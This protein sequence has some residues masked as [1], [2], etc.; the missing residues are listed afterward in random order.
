MKDRIR[1]PLGTNT[2][3]GAVSSRAVGTA[4]GA[5]GQEQR[6]RGPADALNP[7]RGTGGSL[8]EPS[9]LSEPRLITDRASGQGRPDPSKRLVPPP[10]SRHRSS[11]PAARGGGGCRV[12]CPSY[13]WVNCGPERGHQQWARSE[14]QAR[15]LYLLPD[16]LLRPGGHPPET[17]P[18]T[19]GTRAGKQAATGVS[20]TRSQAPTKMTS[21]PDCTSKTCAAPPPGSLQ[22]PYPGRASTA[23]HPRSTTGH[24]GGGMSQKGPS[25][26]LP[27]EGGG[28][29]F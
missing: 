12:R 2:S 25:S 3:L 21:P 20:D 13:R 14:R 16:T 22:L 10:T 23:P 28:L 6:G 27:D 9:C 18:G 1:L 11:F 19:A 4:K 24:W 8:G 29:R 7:A 15:A 5:R 17:P 26:G